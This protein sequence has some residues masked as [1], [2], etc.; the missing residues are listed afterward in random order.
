MI[1]RIFAFLI[2]IGSMFTVCF[3]SQ[4]DMNMAMFSESRIA[5]AEL[6]ATYQETLRLYADNHR[7]VTHLKQAETLWIRYRE[8]YLKSIFPDH[9][10]AF[11]YGSIYPFCFAGREI[12]ITKVRS[13]QL[14][15]Y[16]LYSIKT[17]H[18]QTGGHVNDT[19]QRVLKVYDPQYLND[20]IAAQ[21]AWTAFR[22]ADALAYA[23]FFVAAD[24]D[25]AMSHFYL[26][27]QAEL[28]YARTAD[29]QQWIDGVAQG[30]ACAGSIRMRQD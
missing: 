19:Y 28:D 7:F 11:A 24:E 26:E 8:A 15:D 14:H 21:E 1:E 23:S 3:A 22:D 10:A 27:R 16:I 13:T 17:R 30:E 29:L 20:L 6:D 18:P 4:F 5:D 12:E 2:L 25:P 9:D